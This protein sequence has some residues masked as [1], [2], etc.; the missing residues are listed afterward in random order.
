MA[1]K[2]RYPEVHLKS[3]VHHGNILN[4]PGWVSAVIVQRQIVKLAKKKK[5]KLLKPCRTT[6]IK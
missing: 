2:F 3:I 4:H 6:V 5:E 1:G